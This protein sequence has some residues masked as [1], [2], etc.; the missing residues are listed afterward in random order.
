MCWNLYFPFAL[1]VFA[2]AKMYRRV[3]RTVIIQPILVRLPTN[4]TV[5]LRSSG[6]VFCTVNAAPDNNNV[7]QVM[8]YYQLRAI[9]LL[10]QTVTHL[11]QIYPRCQGNKT[12]IFRIPLLCNKACNF[13]RIIAG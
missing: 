4:I 2:L 11:L 12:R 6:R 5:L 9:I 3:L 8:F 10:A 7:T 1:S 13:W